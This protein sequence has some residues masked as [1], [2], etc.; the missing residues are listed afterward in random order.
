[1]LPMLLN[2]TIAKVITGEDLVL[3]LTTLTRLQ[4]RTADMEV[5][6]QLIVLII[7]MAQE[8]D[9]IPIVQT[10]RMDKV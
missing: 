8:A 2:Y 6:I 5:N 1:M 9:T 10:T 3:I 4:I 7:P